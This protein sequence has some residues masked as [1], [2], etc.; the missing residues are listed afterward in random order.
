MRSEECGVG[1][2]ESELYFLKGVTIGV[3]FVEKCRIKHEVETTELT[4]NS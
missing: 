4:P 2:V 1:G 3:K